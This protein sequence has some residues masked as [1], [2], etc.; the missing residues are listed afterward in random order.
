MLVK[1]K[2]YFM[3]ETYTP[4][5]L[6]QCLF[7]N[8]PNTNIHAY[9]TLFMVSRMRLHNITY[10]PYCPQL[11][12]L[13]DSIRAYWQLHYTSFLSSATLMCTTIIYI[14]RWQ[15]GL[16]LLNVLCKQ[17]WLVCAGSHAWCILMIWWYLE[18]TCLTQWLDSWMSCPDLVMPISEHK[19]SGPC[20][21][22]QWG[23]H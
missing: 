3:N 10:L 12:F 11:G 1:H 20:S 18:R 6:P 13:T 4:L 7:L 8:S 14:K 16:E 23:S 9:P 15:M 5:T 22:S 2:M 21:I 17:S 19:I